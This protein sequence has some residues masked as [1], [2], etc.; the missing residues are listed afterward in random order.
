MLVGEKEFI[1]T[2]KEEEI[3]FAI[4]TRPR[5]VIIGAKVDDGDPRIV[6]QVC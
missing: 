4:M 5:T 3:G 6:E 2:M 1:K